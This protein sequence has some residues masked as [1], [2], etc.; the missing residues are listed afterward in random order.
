MR[1]VFNSELGPNPMIR[2][3]SAANTAICAP[4][5]LNAEDKL[6]KRLKNSSPFYSF[7]AK[8]PLRARAV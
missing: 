3:G 1:R 2:I 4:R 7:G 6:P 8:Y 5:R